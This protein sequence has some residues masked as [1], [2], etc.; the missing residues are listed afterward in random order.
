MD[1]PTS[2]S[3][4][5]RLEKRDALTRHD[6]ASTVNSVQHPTHEASTV[7]SDSDGTRD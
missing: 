7:A 5:C 1:D 2:R 3:A 6:E 4:N